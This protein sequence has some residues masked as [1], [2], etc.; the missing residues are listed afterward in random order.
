[1]HHISNRQDDVEHFLFAELLAA[2]ATTGPNTERLAPAERWRNSN[3][4]AAAE[5][6][7]QLSRNGGTH[8]SRAREEI[9]TR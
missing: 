3:P 1:M 5:P 7:F 4:A 8:S 9:G 2:N 6:R